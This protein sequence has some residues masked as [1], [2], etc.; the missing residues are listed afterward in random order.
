M[1]KIVAFLFLFSC[2]LMAQNNMWPLAKGNKYQ[3]F[4]QYWTY[5]PNPYS[6]RLEFIEVIKDTIIDHKTFY[7]FNSSGDFFRYDGDKN[8]AF[9]WYN[10][11]EELYCDFNVEHDSSFMQFVP[12]QHIFRKVN[13]SLDSQK[14]FGTLLKTFEWTTR[15]TQTWYWRY[16]TFGQNLGVNSRQDS[17][18]GTGSDY[19]YNSSLINAILYDSA[20]NYKYYSN[21]HNPEILFTPFS[22][23]TGNPVLGISSEVNHYYNRTNPIG[24]SSEGIVYIDSVFIESCYGKDTLKTSLER[25]AST[26]L[27]RTK[28]Y[29]FSIPIDTS[30]IKG[31]FKFYY[32]IVAKDKSIIPVYSF[33]PNSGYYEA[34][35]SPTLIENVKDE[36]FSFS[37]SQN[38]PN[39]FNPST[40]I[41]YTI[42][43][44]PSSSP[45]AKGG[46]EVGFVSL[47]V[48]DIL[49]NEVVSLVNEYKLA[50]SYEVEFNAVNLPSGIYFYQLKAGD[51]ES[52][53][54]QVFIETKKMMLLR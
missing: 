29:N 27:T 42:P 45:L 16:E 47:K 30:L 53:S 24:S 1:K 15:G 38:Y 13:V 8:K 48:Y 52:S 14:V 3:Y 43:T 36:L 6:Y 9:I 46:N 28:Q 7:L 35:Y 49:G 10:G 26:R 44:P 11:A 18:F 20:G 21:D 33:S 37:L 22:T 41:R 54:G 31:G 5:V 23:V 50:G 12:I 2:F 34:V 32:R 40:K 25:H 51:P 17:Y 19:D 4:W 39:P